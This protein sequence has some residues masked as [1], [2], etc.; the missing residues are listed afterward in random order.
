LDTFLTLIAFILSVAGAGGCTY[1][2]WKYYESHGLNAYDRHTSSK[3]DIFGRKLFY[4]III[5][6]GAWLVILFILLSIFGL[7]S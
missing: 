2:F 6:V 1:L 7:N 5:L 4:A 3:F